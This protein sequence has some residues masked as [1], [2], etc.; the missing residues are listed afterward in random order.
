MDRRQK[1]IISPFNEELKLKGFKAYTADSNPAPALVY[2]RKDFY[3]ICLLSGKSFVSY[4]DRSFNIDGCS[5]FFGTPHIPYSWDVLSENQTGYA[6]LFT[7]SFLKG[8]DRSESLQ[9][10]PFFKI[11][12]SP[13]FNL[14]QTQR[15]TLAAV[16]QKMIAEQDS[17]Y[18]FKD[19]LIRTYIQL[20]IHEALK[21]QPSS[22]IIKPRNAHTRITSLFFELLERQFPVESANQPL[23]LKTAQDYANRLSIHVNH[24]NRAVKDVTG[25]PTTSH[26]ADRII[27]E[28]K[29]L[30]LHTD[31]PVSDIAFSLGFDY[32]TY[33]NNY[34]KRL[35]GVTP[36]AARLAT[37]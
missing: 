9:E 5:L 31:W 27:S 28:A 7:E 15:D 8:H 26:I 30:L 32:P 23:Q 6:C 13:I 34:F 11:G 14:D 29:A 12:G 1:T 18:A 35:T 33:F 37:A 4:A 20:I 3:K 17:D 36:S 2:S 21:M 24:L 10:S 25:K 19:D 16:F 22:N